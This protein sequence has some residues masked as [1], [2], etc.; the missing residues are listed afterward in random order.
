MPYTVT[1]GRILVCLITS[2]DTRRWII[3]KGWGKKGVFPHDQ[4]A[5]EALE[6][7]GL[8]GEIESDPIGKYEYI[9]DFKYQ[10]RVIVYPMFVIDE[11]PEWKESQQRTRHWVTADKAS[12]LV[13]EQELAALFADLDDILL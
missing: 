10:C 6:E 8:V 12:A 11:R 13:G 2:R 1:A 4:A 9:K 5:R 3:P 7:A